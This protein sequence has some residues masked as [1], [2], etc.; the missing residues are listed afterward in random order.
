MKRKIQ[1]KAIALIRVSTEMQAT[2]NDSID[3][4]EKSILKWAEEKGFEIE[5]FYHEPGNSAFRGK[6]TI[7]EQIKND[8]NEGAV[9]PNAMV[10]YSY[11]RFTRRAS[12][13]ASFKSFLTDREIPL[14][15]VTEPMPNDED[16]AFISQTVIDMVNELQSRNNSKVVQDRLNDTAEKGYF[17]GGVVPYG[18][19]SVPVT[20]PGS[21]IEKKQ[22]IINKE[23]AEIVRKIF[24]LSEQGL[25]GKP[26]GVFEIAK[27]LNSMDITNRGSRWTKNKISDIL[28]KTIYYGERVW[29]N[30]RISR[31]ESNPPITIKVP[32]IITKEQ[33]NLVK[34]G[35]DARRPLT[36]TNIA[37]NTLS[38]GLRS[39]TLLVGLLKCELCGSN[40]RLMNGKK[41][42]TKDGNSIRYQYY[43][44]PNRTDKGCQC[45]NIRRDHL[46]AIIKESVVLNVLNTD[47]ISEVVVEIKDQINN[48]IKGNENRLL[49]L[50][51]KKAQLKSQ[52]NNLYDKVADG[53]FEMDEVLKE[54]L[55]NKK[56]ALEEVGFSIQQI[57]MRSKIPLKKFGPNQIN[58]FV[59]ASKK[60]LAGSNEDITK[61]LLLKI[62]DKILVSKKKVTVFGSNFKLA[63][64]VSKTKMGTSLEVPTFVSIWR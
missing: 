58:A 26:L 49:N 40:L 9:C 50:N 1:Y 7:L 20:I 6:R 25:N 16:T 51:K 59:K 32:A 14:I 42:H 47:V 62:V 56:V 53:V 15:S 18:Y 64:I 45:P 55:D 37:I 4:Q 43:R 10:V 36:N 21:L 57:Q 5:K 11:S 12:N 17:T 23:E 30:K 46:D 52:I 22:L 3:G 38:K 31:S 63:E 54:N 61:Q 33:F 39:N 41:K 34:K 28:N 60:V 2:T 24:D 27:H 29:G 13:T 44:C 48:L 19:S 8:I 35:L